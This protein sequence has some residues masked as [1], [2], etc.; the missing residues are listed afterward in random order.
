M[1]RWGRVLGAGAG[2]VLVVGGVLGLDGYSWGW[3]FGA[4]AAAAGAFVVSG[5][6]GPG[7]R[8]G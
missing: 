4:A 2:V 1:S 8:S 7:K 6:L 5:A 3:V